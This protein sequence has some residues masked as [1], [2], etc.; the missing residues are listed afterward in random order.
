MICRLGDLHGMEFIELSGMI[1]CGPKSVKTLLAIIE[2]A[3]AGEF[4]GLQRPAV[5]SGGGFA[6]SA[7]F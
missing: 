1:G 4:K 6:L 3:G 2:R 7:S 5:G